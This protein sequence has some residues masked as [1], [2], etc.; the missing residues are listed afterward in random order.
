MDSE[1]EDRSGADGR[2]GKGSPADAFEAIVEGLRR[3]GPIPEWPDDVTG[4][5]DGTVALDDVG[6]VP[7]RNQPTTKPDD[8]L[9]AA[10]PPPTA[11]TTP[12]ASPIDE[13]DDEHYVPPEPPPLPKLGPPAA[14]GLVLLG[15]G[16][17]L[18]IAPSVLGLSPR[19]GLPLGLLALAAGL[20][21]LVLRLWPSPPQ[22]GTGDGEDD[23]AVV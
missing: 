2:S 6:I 3:E 21:W 20:G 23:G 15:L 8:S 16:L 17:L 4:P 18:C 10:S 11:S 14:V 9:F 1:P 22:R 12:A 19:F 13:D 5:P 7:P